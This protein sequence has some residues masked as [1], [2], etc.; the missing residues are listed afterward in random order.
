MVLLDICSAEYTKGA[1]SCL[2]QLLATGN[3]FKIGEKGFLFHLKSSFRSQ[4]IEIFI[5]TFLVI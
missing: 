2:R 3:S 4:D 1:V 5:L